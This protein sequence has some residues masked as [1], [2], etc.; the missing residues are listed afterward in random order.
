MICYL[1]SSALVKRYV[2]EQGSEEV[3]RLIETSELLGTALLTRTEVVAAFAKAV[4]VG[5]LS[6]DSATEARKRFEGDWNDLVRLAVAEG[7]VS[8]AADFAW[9]HDLRAYDA[10]HLA[11]ARSLAD[12]TGET[13]LFATFDR[14]LWTAS[15][16][17][18]LH[19]WPEDLPRLLDSWNA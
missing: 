17:E 12:L 1:D 13:L 2:T 18:E 11:A 15:D 10:L 4:R 5:A 9:S 14:R 3:H 6:E 16:N 19:P 8:R 7:I